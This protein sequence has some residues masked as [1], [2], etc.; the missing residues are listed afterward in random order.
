VEVLIAPEERAGWRLLLGMV[1]ASRQI[2]GLDAEGPTLDPLTPPANL[3]APLL[4]IEPIVVT[5]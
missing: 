2:A 4:A 3:S 5:Q 1:A